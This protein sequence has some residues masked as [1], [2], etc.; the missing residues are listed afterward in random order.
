MKAFTFTCSLAVLL[1]MACS[2]AAPG[3]GLTRAD[4]GVR[5]HA[6]STYA[7]PLI[8]ED[9]P[10]PVVIKAADGYF[11][12]YATQGP[13]KGR[14]DN[15]PVSRSTDLTHWER[16]PDAMPTKPAWASATQNFWAPHVTERGGKYYMY[17]SAEP[18][19]RQGLAIG[20]AVADSP[21]GPFKDTGAPLVKGPGFENIDPFLLEDAGRLYLYW[22]SGFK[23]IKVQEMTPDGLHFLPG[24]QPKDVL[25]PSQSPYEHLVEGTWVVKRDGWYYLFYSGDNCCEKTPFYSVMVARSRRPEGPFQK[26]AEATGAPDSAIVRADAAWQAPGHNTVITDAAGQDWILYHA[27]DVRHPRN[28]DGSVRRAMLIDKL[29]YKDGWPRLEADGPTSGKRPGPV[30]R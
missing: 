30:L 10:D 22:G 2:Q 27:I 20:V 1:V 11:Y 26:L 19:E 24:T 13:Y 25:S 29:V 8:D 17:Y 7:N 12:A 23:P 16:L 3:A 14:Y 9:Y 5:A 6:A 18:N 28:P 15:I 21:A 4:A